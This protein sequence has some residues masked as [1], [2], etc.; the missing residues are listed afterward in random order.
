VTF[1]KRILRALTYFGVILL[2]LI[3]TQVVTFLISLFLPIS[4][5]LLLNNPIVFAAL[6]GFTF[7]LGVFLT[8]WLAIKL[9]WLPLPPK[10]LHRLLGALLGAYLPLAAALLIFR[11]LQPGSPFFFASIVGSILG[12]Y[13]LGWEDRNR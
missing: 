13:V 6:V 1:G 5:N 2:Q 9:R 11:S 10:T 4:E 7:A 3:M 12:F 8:G